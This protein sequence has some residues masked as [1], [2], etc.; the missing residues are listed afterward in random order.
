MTT[1]MTQDLLEALAK[2]RHLMSEFVFCG[3]EG[4]PIHRG[5][6]RKP[7]LRAI[8]KS[9]VKKIRFHD[10]RHC[11]AS[12]LVICNV[13]IKRVQ[14]LLGHSDLKMT[15]R[16]SHLTPACREE[17]IK[18]LEEKISASMWSQSGHPQVV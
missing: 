7:L 11:F 12:H 13:R 15:L 1:P 14:E 4:K 2:T 6:V 16:Y 8:E 18:A 9:G 3:I 5:S 17:A 10:L